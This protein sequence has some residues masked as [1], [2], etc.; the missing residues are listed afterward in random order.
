MATL[1]KKIKSYCCLFN[2][3]SIAIEEAMEET[4]LIHKV[5]QF[6]Y[7]MFLHISQSHIEQ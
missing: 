4:N 5:N 7:E 6:F 3:Y 2:C 1:G